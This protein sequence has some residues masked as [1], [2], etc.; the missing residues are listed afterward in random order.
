MARMD[1]TCRW[2]Y[3]FTPDGTEPGA[4][5]IPPTPTPTYTPSATP[6]P[7]NTPVILF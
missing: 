7:T 2:G 4:C 6:T 3:G 1:N 5:F